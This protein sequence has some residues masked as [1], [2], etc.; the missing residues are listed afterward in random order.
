LIACFSFGVITS[1][2]DWRNYNLCVNAMQAR[3]DPKVGPILA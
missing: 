1:D 2:W 3:T